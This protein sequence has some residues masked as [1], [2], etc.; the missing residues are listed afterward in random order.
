MR[1]FLHVIESY[2]FLI[3]LARSG[4][5]AAGFLLPDRLLV[6][7]AGRTALARAPLASAA[8]AHYLEGSGRPWRVPALRI[9]DGD[10]GV[11]AWLTPRIRARH[12]AGATEGRV[13]V[14]QGAWT[15]LDRRFAI[16]GLRVHWRSEGRG[17][18]AVGFDKLY[19]WSPRESRM[20]RA[21]HA[22][23]DRL[24][25][26]GARPFRILGMPG[27]LPLCAPDQPTGIG[28]VLL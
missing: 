20:T 2:P 24:R 11:L 22:A 14:P 5:D 17:R 4:L 16:G 15:D 3:P 7:A 27:R 26:Q 23:A 8:L 9:L 21:V 19:R 12:A 25:A 1:R 10:P 28:K 13:D 18:V 6:A